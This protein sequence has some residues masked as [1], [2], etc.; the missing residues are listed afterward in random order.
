MLNRKRMQKKSQ[1]HTT[2]EEIPNF[3]LPIFSNSL[4]FGKCEIHIMLLYLLKMTLPI[5]LPPQSSVLRRDYCVIQHVP[6]APKNS[7]TRL[8]RND[9][10]DLILKA[11][12]TSRGKVK[13]IGILLS[14]AYIYVML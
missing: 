3:P 13:P 4:H 14:Y 11:S 10:L 5:K 7:T 9:G 12:A 6:F 2:V 1:P 8:V